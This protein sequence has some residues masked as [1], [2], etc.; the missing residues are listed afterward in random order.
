MYI[1]AKATDFK[2]NIRKK[3]ERREP[4]FDTAS[5]KVQVRKDYGNV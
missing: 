3:L 5:V 2:G 1:L 4:R